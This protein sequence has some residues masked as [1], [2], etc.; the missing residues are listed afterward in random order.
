MKLLVDKNF[1]CKKIYE[2][3]TYLYIEKDYQR[4][5]SD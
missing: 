5:V 3:D 1:E 4:N 2:E